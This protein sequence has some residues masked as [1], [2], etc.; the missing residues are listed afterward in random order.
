MLTE[1]ILLPHT[2]KCAYYLFL[3]VTLSVCY[4]AQWRTGPVCHHRV[5]PACAQ[6]PWDLCAAA[7]DRCS[8]LHRQLAPCLHPAAVWGVGAALRE[9][10]A[11]LPGVQR[12]HRAFQELRLRGV[13]EEGLGSQGQVRAVGKAAGLPHALRPLDRGGL[14]HL[15]AAALQVSVRRPPSPEPADSPRPPQ[16]PGWHTCA[17][18]LPGQIHHHTHTHRLYSN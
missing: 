9:P 13:H 1:Q 2:P 17:S 18:L 5:P 15:P 11:L 4:P 3:S 14:P 8:A 7:A 10:G 12:L 16:R 6:G